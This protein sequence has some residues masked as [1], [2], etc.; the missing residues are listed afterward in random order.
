MNERGSPEAKAS[1]PCSMI[2]STYP[3]HCDSELV[4]T[5]INSPKP[6]I[7]AVNGPAIGISVPPTLA[8]M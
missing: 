6:L 8:N 1:K 5:I 4:E 3:T 2:I 7:A